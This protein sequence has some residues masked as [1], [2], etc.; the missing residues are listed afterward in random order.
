M[1]HNK[2]GGKGSLKKLM[3]LSY[4]PEDARSCARA[5]CHLQSWE[6]HL[7]GLRE[8]LCGCSCVYVWEISNDERIPFQVW[9]GGATKLHPFTMRTH[10]HRHVQTLAHT[11]TP[12]YR[13]LLLT[14]AG[15]SPSVYIC[16]QVSLNELNSI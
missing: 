12:S 5:V 10:T 16:R 3:T 1:H 8:R 4:G 2:E 9:A 6:G 14:S 13:P 7:S 15:A 11:H